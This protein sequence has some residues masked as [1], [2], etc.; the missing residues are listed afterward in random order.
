MSAFDEWV[1][2]ES[3]TRG[4]PSIGEENWA[5]AGFKG[6]YTA[7]RAEPMRV[8]REVGECKRIKDRSVE[9]ARFSLR[10]V[11]TKSEVLEWTECERQY[12]QRKPLAWASLFALIAAEQAEKPQT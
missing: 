7:G 12:Q 11:L 8:L 4:E 1:K 9:L 2:L 5:Y 3:A 6:G 10:R